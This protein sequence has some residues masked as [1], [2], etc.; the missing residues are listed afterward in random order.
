MDL[1]KVTSNFWKIDQSPLIDESTSEYHYNE[2]KQVNVDVT[3]LENY[4]LYVTLPGWKHLNKAYLYVK[5][6]IDND[7]NNK[8]TVSNNG[9]NDFDYARL[10]YENTEMESIEHVGITTTILNL[11][12]FSGD[13]SDTVASQL[14][15]YLDTFDGT[16]T[17]PYIYEEENK[18]VKLKELDE[19]IG[20]IVS[21]IKQN[22]KYNNGFFKRWNLTKNKQ[23]IVKFIPLSNIF[24]FARD[25]NKVLNGDIKIEL[26]KNKTKNIL[27]A[28][29]VGNY[30]YEI[31]YVSLWIPIVKPSLETELYLSKILISINPSIIYGWN[32]INTY[33]SNIQTSSTGSWSIGTYHHKISKVFIVFSKKDR[34]Q[35]FVKSNMIFDNMNLKTIH[36]K[37]NGE[38]IPKYEYSVDFSKNDYQRLYEA[39]QSCNYKEGLD[40]GT[41]VNYKDFGSIYPIICFD[42]TKE[43]SESI[44]SATKVST[45]EVHWELQDHNNE[46][47]YIYSIV[48]TQ[49]V[50]HMNIENNKIHLIKK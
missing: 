11:T 42:I 30:K 20:S 40:E 7:P 46:N 22:P 17:N 5:S 37:I 45:L 33:R 23:I 25:V 39:F 48:E 47:Y 50:A 43:N 6:F 9:I 44:F 34:E 13:V 18:N 10:D 31:S 14:L 32:A 19:S 49:R 27:H 15:W 36:I 1:E 26:R 41:C 21:K 12:E 8:A 24:R 29:E 38:K 3:N 28:K 16:N 4:D 2:I 35:N